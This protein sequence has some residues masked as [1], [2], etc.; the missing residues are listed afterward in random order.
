[1]HV[2][3]KLIASY[4]SA[5]L[6]LLVGLATLFQTREAEDATQRTTAVRAVA[7]STLDIQI[8]LLDA[9]SALRGYLLTSDRGYLERY[10]R[11][12]PEVDRKVGALPSLTTNPE[13]LGR[14]TA[15]K[16]HTELKLKELAETARAHDSGG[17]A[18]AI[19]KAGTRD[20]TTDKITS[21]ASE[22]VAA[23]RLINDQGEQG[24]GSFRTFVR[25]FT[26]LGNVVAF[27]L[28]MAVTSWIARAFKDLQAANVTL[29]SHTAKL[30]SQ[31]RAAL[32]QLAE[33]RRLTESLEESNA[34]LTRSNKDLE[35]IAYIASH[36]LRA[37]LRGIANL[38][39][40]IEDDMGGA[41]T[42]QIKQHLSSMRG[43]IRR[44]EALIEGVV[45]YSRAGREAP[46]ADRVDVAQL[47]KETVDLLAVPEN[48]RVTVSGAMP[49]IAAL[50]VPLQQV[51]MNLIANAVK[52]GT[53]NGGEVKVAVTEVGQFLSF[54]VSDSGPGIAPRYHETI[55]G[56]FRTLAPRD[57]V[58]GAGIGLALVKKLTD[59]YGGKVHVDSGLGKGATFT[60][61]WPKTFGKSG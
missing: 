33:Q 43:R 8:L 22:I 20:G 3:T 27:L 31:E 30:A 14:A 11:Q 19:V 32:A 46:T 35:Q 7:R 1:V 36:D 4:A 25:W 24:A 39:E 38:A 10:L 48:V 40:W 23:A 5:T 42:D 21:Q 12:A 59:R 2:R 26:G 17:D 18:V 53:P 9:E 37:P 50:R 28:G 47:M 55:F 41:A 29:E 6:V 54:S 60:F 57:R 45:A 51:L 34:A 58:E 49:V 15:L 56:L 44:L 16:G 13:Q 52:H 61:L